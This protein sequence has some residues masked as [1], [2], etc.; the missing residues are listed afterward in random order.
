MIFNFKLFLKLMVLGVLT[1]AHANENQVCVSP[2]PENI[3]IVLH[4]DEARRLQIEVY[5]NDQLIV[6]EENLYEGACHNQGTI[7]I[8]KKLTYGGCYHIS[9]PRRTLLIKPTN[10]KYDLNEYICTSQMASVRIFDSIDLRPNNI[11]CTRICGG[12]EGETR[13]VCR[14]IPSGSECNTGPKMCKV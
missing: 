6:H 2:G 8:G 11:C 3:K 1:A 10:T 7:Y 5:E 9:P 13:S 14:E 12:R 4:S